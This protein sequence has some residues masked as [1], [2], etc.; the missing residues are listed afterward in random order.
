MKERE[1]RERESVCVSVC[2]F[3]CVYTTTA[4]NRWNVG[5]TNCDSCSAPYSFPKDKPTCSPLSPGHSYMFS[6]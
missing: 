1:E 2:M 4:A 6:K 3:V 5:D